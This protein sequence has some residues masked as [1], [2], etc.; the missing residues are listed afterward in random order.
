MAMFTWVYTTDW[1]FC[2]ADKLD[3]TSGAWGG[4]GPPC[5]K[6]PL[7]KVPDNSYGHYVT[8]Q[9]LYAYMLKKR[10]DIHVASARLVHIPTDEESP[11][12]REIMLTLLDDATIEAMFE[13]YVHCAS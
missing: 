11:V 4:R 8:Q 13:E 9:S 10:Y 3:K 5:G 7:S 12:A 6:G 2:Q 1:K